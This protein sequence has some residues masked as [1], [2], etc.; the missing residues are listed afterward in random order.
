MIVKHRWIFGDGFESSEEDPIHIYKMPG[1]YTWHHSIEDENENTISGSTGTITVTEEYAISGTNTSFSFGL[2]KAQG[3]YFRE[4]TGAHFP[5]PPSRIGGL[6]VVDSN[7]IPH[8]LI[9][10][11]VDR[12]YYAMDTFDGPSGTQNSIYWKDKVAADG[13]GGGDFTSKTRF[14]EDKGESERFFLRNKTQHVQ[15]RP[16]RKSY[17]G[18]TG[19]DANGFP[20]DLTLDIAL[21]KDGERTSHTV[22]A[23]DV[24]P[25]KHEIHFD[26]QVRDAN[27]LQLEVVGNKAPYRIVSKHSNIIVY[28]RQD[29][30]DGKKSNEDTWQENLNNDL[31]A[32]LSRGGGI[33][34]K[35]TNTDFT[36]VGTPAYVT[37]PDDKSESA[38][39]V[40]TSV[41]LGNSA[42]ADGLLLIWHKSGYTITGVTLTEVTTSGSWILSKATGAFSANVILGAG[43]VFD[44]RLYDASK[45][46]ADIT[47]YHTDITENEGNNVMDLF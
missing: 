8:T 15:L 36:V 43:D 35:V 23:E 46:D 26:R 37:G 27:R 45:T 25:P 2:N 7:G 41:D 1:V 31:V 38:L 16:A 21:Y 44:V 33:T 19:Y 12:K 10:D 40:P 13:S 11:A 3:I 17:R 22:K 47:Y 34:N 42:I 14:G 18:A 4:N 20:T 39:T 28:D 6:K 29:D 9:F 24:S 5:K 30:P 32:W